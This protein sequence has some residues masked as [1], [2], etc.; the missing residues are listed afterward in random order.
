[1]E[2]MNYHHL[3]YFWT[4]VR[5]GSIAKASEELRVSSPND[6]SCSLEANFG[7]KLLRRSGRN[8]VLTEM[9]RVVF[10]YAEDIFNV[11]PGTYGYRPES[12]HWAD[13]AA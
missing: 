2:W 13:H 4:V 9:G 7:D 12:S 11:G 6:H 5:T 1:M 8:L 10:G 3:L